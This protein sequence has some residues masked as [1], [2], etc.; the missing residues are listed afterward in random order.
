MQAGDFGWSKTEN[1]NENEDYKSQCYVYLRTC[2][3]LF[4]FSQCQM[5]V[6]FTLRRGTRRRNIPHQTKSH[7]Y[8]HFKVEEYLIKITV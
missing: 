5:Y 6:T 2:V 4:V 1:A 3:T 7:S 8:L